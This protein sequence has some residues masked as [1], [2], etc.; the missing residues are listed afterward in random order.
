MYNIK[1]LNWREKAVAYSF[2][3]QSCKA[4]SLKVQGIKME[5]NAA[6]SKSRRRKKTRLKCNYKNWVVFF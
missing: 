6:I 5:K 3:P 2:F 4:F 1:W